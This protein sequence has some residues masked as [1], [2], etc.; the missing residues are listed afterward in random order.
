MSPLPQQD[1]WELAQRHADRGQW[2]DALRW[3]AEAEKKNKMRPEVYHLRGVIEFQ[4]KEFDKAL[5][6]LRQAIYC[7]GNF[8]LAHFTLG[9]LY[10]KQGN[11]KKAFYQWNQA[12]TILATLLPE[13]PIAFSG[14]LT[15]EILLG[16]LQYRL[17][18]LPIKS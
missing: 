6:S 5:S 2:V 12:Q 11:F 1:P 14:D 8:V 9:E 4:Q 7:D 3:L 18:S 13:Q 15:V 17:E 10:E 16:I